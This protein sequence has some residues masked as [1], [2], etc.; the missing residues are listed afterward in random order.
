[1]NE[2]L[3]FCLSAG[4]LLLGVGSILISVL[5]VYRFRFVMNRMHA[6]AI[7]DTLGAFGILVGL[8]F[9]A[10]SWEY[11]PKLVLIL[12]F[13]WFGSPLSSHFVSRLEISTNETASEHMD[14][15]DRT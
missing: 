4:F 6:A 2:T 14:Q 5:G 11:I 8:M 1:M 15:E 9:A 10:G 13:L 7:T 3:R 12:A